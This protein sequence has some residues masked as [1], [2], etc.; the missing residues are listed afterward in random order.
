MAGTTTEVLELARVEIALDQAA[1]GL[2]GLR[3]VMAPE[4]AAGFSGIAMHSAD[5]SLRIELAEGIDSLMALIET[6]KASIGLEVERLL[7][8]GP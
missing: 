1:E 7:A 8:G 6:A 4:F 3:G 5:S 2:G